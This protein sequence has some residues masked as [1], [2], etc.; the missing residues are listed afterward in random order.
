[1]PGFDGLLKEISIGSSINTDDLLPY[2]C[3]ESS[4]DRLWVNYCLADAYHRA[5]N[6]E[7][8]MVFIRRAWNFSGQN[9]K[10]LPLLV[11][12]HAAVGDIESIRAVHKALGMKKA[13]ADKVSAALAHFNSWQ[14]AYAVHNKSDEYCY[15]FEVLDCISQLAGKYAFP[16]RRPTSWAKR[17]IRLAYLMFG[18]THLNSVIVKNSLTFSSFHDASRFE[19]TFFIPDQATSVLE[20][21]E[22]AENIRKIKSMGWKVVLAPDSFSEVK[23]L[24]ELA[25]FIYESEPDILV[26]NAALADFRHFYIASLKPAPVVVGL[27]QGPPPQYIAPS[28]DWSI[29]W[30]KHPMMDCPTGCTLVNGAVPLPER[31]ISN[32]AAKLHFGIAE[33]DRVMMSCG[34]MSKFQH[35]GIWVAIL[36]MLRV[37]LETH[38][39]VVG[40]DTPPSFLEQLLTPDIVRRVRFIGRVDDYHSVLSMADVVIDTYPSGGGM[41]VVDAMAMGIPVVSFKNNYMRMFSQADWSPAEEFMGMPELLIERGDFVQLGNLLNKLLTDHQYRNEMSVMCK[42]RIHQTSGKPEKMVRDC[43]AVY[44]KLLQSRALDFDRIKNGR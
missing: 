26:T 36:D 5:G 12:I 16:V 7:Y 2:L 44:L 37:H 43:E 22:A 9:E 19:V 14:Y 32:S 38:Y 13:S 10:F 33:H 40:L 4:Q 1:M 39:V 21:K 30:T 15:D 23:S 27:C 6:N 42:E 41:T 28:F 17:K 24:H 29:S 11:M 35:Q 20:R 3:R 8:A 18:M 25:R 31:K 34:R